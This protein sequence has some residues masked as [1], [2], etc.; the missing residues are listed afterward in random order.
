VARGV[1]SVPEIVFRVI[2][3]VLFIVYRVIRKVWEARLRA[4]LKE[5]P[6]LQRAPM[7]ERVLLGVMGV[8]LVPLMLWF[9]SP[10]VDFARVPLPEPIRW[11]G[12]FVLAAGVW[13]FSR[14][15]AALAH[16]WAPVL[17]VREGATLV[18]TGPYRLVRH[19]MYS[20]ALVV[21]VGVSVLSANWL[22]A[23]GVLLGILVVIAGRI[24]DEERMMVDAFG[25]EYRAYMQRTGR[26]VPRLSAILRQ[27]PA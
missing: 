19:P 18:T 11:A 8:L 2:G 10:W 6:T 15:H 26:L 25:D 22:A 13:F 3:L 9:V 20:A 16:N 21:N 5:T 27:R 24:P 14:T 12:A 23:T 1:R 17:E 7:R 4:R